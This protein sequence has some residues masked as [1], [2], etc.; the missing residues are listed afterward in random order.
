[1][2]KAIRSSLSA[3]AVVTT[4]ALLL[5]GCSSAASPSTTTSNPPAESSS[6]AATPLSIGLV[7]L[8]GDDYF[9]NVES[10][11]KDAVAADGNTMTAANSNNDPGTEASNVQNMIQSKVSALLMQPVSA[12]SSVATI[13]AADAAGIPVI[14]YGNCSDK[15]SDPSLVKGVAQSDNT[16]LG[17]ATGEEAA[18]YIKTN[19]GGSAKIG[20]LN[21]DTAAETCKLRKAGFK[22]ALADAGIKAEYVTDQEG[23]LADK[24]TTVAVNI[25][26]AN[27]EINLLWASNEGGTVGAVTAVKQSGSKAV[28]FGTDISEQIAQMVTADDNILQATTG[29][30]PKG[31]IAA[32]YEMAKNAV[33]GKTNDPLEKDL[34]GITYKRSDP[35]TVQSYLDGK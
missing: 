15:T 13:Q 34:P 32:A 12:D 21:C 25:L 31:T 27:P 11:L 24:A 19:L 14:C 20:I 28:V 35:T 26:S 17:S 7:M 5:A 2:I 23:Y 33:A 10:G 4:G 16:A 22:Q 1:M 9:Q 6:A 29:Q 18:A 3:A 8:Q 30:D